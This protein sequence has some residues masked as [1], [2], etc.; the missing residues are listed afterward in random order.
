MQCYN[1]V[2]LYRKQ[3]VHRPKHIWSWV[4]GPG[5]W[6]LGPGSWVLGPG[7]WVLGPGSWVLVL[8]PGFFFSGMPSSRLAPEGSKS[9]KINYQRVGV[10]SLLFFQLDKGVNFPKYYLFVF[11]KPKTL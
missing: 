10:F 5:S 11:C 2:F 7:S 8:G 4:L 3:R 1:L 6:V 9:S